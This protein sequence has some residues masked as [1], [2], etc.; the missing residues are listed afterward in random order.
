MA[1]PS[2]RAGRGASCGLRSTP[3]AGSWSRNG[4][5]RSCGTAGEVAP[6]AL[7]CRWSQWV[8]AT[9]P[10]FEEVVMGRGDYEMLTPG[11]IDQLWVRMRA[12]RAAKPTARALGLS[13][14]TVRSY[15]LRCGGI[16]PDPR[17]RPPG[18]L[19]FAEREEISRGLA[20]GWSLRAIA[21]VLGRAPS[22]VSRE[23]TAHGGRGRYRAG[24]PRTK[25]RGRRRG[26]PRPASSQRTR[27]WP[28][29]L[30]RS[31]GVGGHRSRSPAG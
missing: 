8:S 19:S 7:T 6:D 15:L 29:W 21:A 16:R 18:R 23:V 3:T 31:C 27:P 10:W 13:P 28:M 9:L 4:C 22:T 2:R 17:R 30:P 1:A 12:G 20:A 25:G 14:S 26:V 24:A 11:V 5:R